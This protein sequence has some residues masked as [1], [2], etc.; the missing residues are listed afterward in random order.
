M[1]A[2]MKLHAFFAVFVLAHQALANPTAATPVA[3]DEPGQAPTPAAAA[4]DTAAAPAPNADDGWKTVIDLVTIGPGDHLWTSF[5]HTALSVMRFNAST[6]EYNTTVYNWGDADFGGFGFVWAFFRGKALFRITSMGT[7]EDVV[8]QYAPLNRTLVQQRFAFTAA[9]AEHVAERLRFFARPENRDY[10]YHHRHA[11]CATKVR[12]FLDEEVLGGALAK[13]LA[14]TPDRMTPREYGRKYFAGFFFAE[15]FNDMFMGRR[16]DQHWSKFDALTVPDN[17]A[18]YLTEVTVDDPAGTGTKVPLISK[19]V[20][21]V[22]D[23]PAPPYRGEGRSLIHMAYLLLT[24]VIAMGIYALRRSRVVLEDAGFWLL[25]WALP[26]AFVAG[27]MVFGALVST[28]IEGRINELMIVYPITDLILPVVGV[29]WWRGRPFLPNWLWYYAWLRLALV[30][31]AL[32]GHATGL[33]VQEPR[34]V[35]LVALVSASLWVAMMYRL[36]KAQ[37]QVQTDA[38][39][40]PCL[41]IVVRARRSARAGALQRRDVDLPTT[42]Q[43]PSWR[44]QHCLGRW[45]RPRPNRAY[46]DR[47]S[48]RATNRGAEYRESTAPKCCTCA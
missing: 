26:T 48:A 28:V 19:P 4:T 43:T 34:I 17:L 32:L 25:I 10:V 22:R 41:L 44:A 35:L 33:L 39:S 1:S 23:V 8:N 13:Q 3:P 47:Y 27:S 37:A 2:G 12:D 15:L 36:R 31:V 45:R 46:A 6:K 14:G 38:E 42:A 9:Q 29:M 5:G 20:P 40:A 21:I 7:L 18:S 30:G 16:H 11:T 24:L